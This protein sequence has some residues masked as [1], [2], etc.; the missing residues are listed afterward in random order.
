MWK[1]LTYGNKYVFLTEWHTK[2]GEKMIEV[3]HSYN[4]QRNTEWNR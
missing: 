4:L 3:A 1:N 2:L